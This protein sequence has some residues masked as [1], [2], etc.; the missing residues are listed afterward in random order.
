LSDDYAGIVVGEHAELA[1]VLASGNE[2]DMVKLITSHLESAYTR[3]LA[4]FD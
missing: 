2:E 4:S 1:K 3:L